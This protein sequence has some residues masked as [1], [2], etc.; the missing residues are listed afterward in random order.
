MSREQVLIVS[1]GKVQAHTQNQSYQLKPSL[2]AEASRSSSRIQPPKP[3]FHHQIK[4]RR[5]PSCKYRTYPLGTDASNFPRSPRRALHPP[6][7][8]LSPLVPEIQASDYQ[9]LHRLCAR[10]PIL[11]RRYRCRA[12]RRNRGSKWRDSESVGRERGRCAYFPNASVEG[13][14]GNAE[15]GEG[16]EA[17]REGTSHQGGIG[18]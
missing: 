4:P 10:A 7:N 13:T 14:E 3:P 15:E 6:L 1:I 9:I 11:R 18:E 8:N 5:R 16:E 12:R 17:A 2:Q